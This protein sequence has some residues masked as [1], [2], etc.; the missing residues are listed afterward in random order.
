[1]YTVGR[2]RCFDSRGGKKGT[3]FVFSLQPDPLGPF[4]FEILIDN[5]KNIYKM[6]E[7]IMA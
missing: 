7:K 3:V 4:Q 2:W 5:L 1:M 6:G